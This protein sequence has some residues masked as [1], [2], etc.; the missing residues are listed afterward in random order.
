MS[1]FF[2]QVIRKAETGQ[3]G[4]EFMAVVRAEEKRTGVIHKPCLAELQEAQ[5]RDA[6]RQSDRSKAQSK[7]QLSR[8]A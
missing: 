6:I 1:D 3:L 8:A 4:R 7:A 2:S 5:R